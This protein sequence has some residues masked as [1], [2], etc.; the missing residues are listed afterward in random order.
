MHRYGYARRL[1]PRRPPRPCA[2][3]RWASGKATASPTIAWNT[4]RHFELYYAISGIGAVCHTINPRLF[5][6]Q[7]AMSSTTP[8][9]RRFSWTP[10]L[11]P[12]VEKLAPRFEGVKRYVVMT[13]R[14]H[15]PQTSL[16][17]ALCYEELLADRPETYDWPALDERTAA[18]MC[19]TSGTT[20]NPKGSLYHHRSTVLHALGLLAAGVVPLGLGETV[21]PVVP[22]FH[23]QAW[24]QPYAAPIAGREA[25]SARAEARRASLAALMDA[26]GVTVTLGVPTIW[27]GLLSTCARPAGARPR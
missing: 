21:L 9:T 3:T 6:D 26:E 12:L 25:G 7:L 16:P 8:G 23:V 5:A 27:L 15:M 1:P 20:G 22:M 2:R 17:G 18:A 13:D 10:I 11:A 19:Y 4:H 14:E 24:G